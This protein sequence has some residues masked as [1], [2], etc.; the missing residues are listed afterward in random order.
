VT[1]VKSAR[2]I[3]EAD[4]RDRTLGRVHLSLATRNKREAERAHAAVEA[5][6]RE[7][8]ADLLHLLRRR[9]LNVAAVRATFEAR[10]PFDALRAGWAW[11][12]LGEAVERYL[13]W[14]RAHPDRADNTA[15]NADAL[16]SAALEHFGE[17]ARVDTIAT[18]A[19]T[20]WR[21]IL[22]VGRQ[23]ITATRYVQRLGALYTW[24][25]RRED[26]RA[27]EEKRAPRVLHSPVDP[28]IVSGTALG[29]SRRV[30]FLTPEEA[31]R[32]LAATPDRLRFPVL[33]GLLAGLRV[34][35]T[36]HLTPADVDLELGLVVVESKPAPWLR[37]GVW[38]PKGR[39]R[40]DVPLVP[41]LA[42][43]ARAHL[44][45]VASAE[46]MLPT[47]H[48]DPRLAGRPLSQRRFTEVFTRVVTDAGLIPGR[49][50]T[51]GVTYH[52]LRHTFASWLVM[53]GVDLFTVSRLLGH[54]TTTQVEATY[55]HLSPEH[56]AQAVARLARRFTLRLAEDEPNGVGGTDVPDSATETAD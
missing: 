36:L 30:R 48:N 12:A 11:P 2:G 53:E 1:L 32:L 54:T 34:D 23:P 43:A 3:F 9:K 4:I 28:E 39:R 21:E 50:E 41:D 40:R 42:A 47:R 14:L 6:I 27:L 46:W 19:V 38:H 25:Q 24:L 22:S 20:A 51:A 33:G 45:T 52:T 13:G 37:R 26:R 56:R 8:H 18:D 7:G 16:L 55:G 49:N 31:T 44:E 5:L 10:R 35:E 17:G 29:T 15:K